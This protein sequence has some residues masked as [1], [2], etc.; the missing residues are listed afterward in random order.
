MQNESEWE[1]VR[2]SFVHAT[3]VRI[4][5][6]GVENQQ[7]RFGNTLAK[8]VVFTV[9]QTAVSFALH[10]HFQTLLRS[11]LLFAAVSFTH[12]RKTRIVFLLLRRHA[13]VTNL[14]VL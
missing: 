13:A 11:F 14:L 7:R 2:A 12:R 5:A 6:R 3:F 4:T 9:L 8:T 1:C 10:S